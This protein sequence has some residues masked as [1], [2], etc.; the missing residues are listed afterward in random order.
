MQ[1][2][3]T[4]K[5]KNKT[6]T[7]NILITGAGGYIGSYLLNFLGKNTPNHIIPLSKKWPEHFY[8]WKDKFNVIEADVT[9]LD[10]LQEKIPQKIDIII[11]LAA[12]NNIKTAKMPEKALIVNGIGT[13]NMLDVA[14]ERNCRLFIYFSVLQ[15]YGKELA[16][17]ITVDSSLNCSDDYALTHF[18]AEEY[19]RMLSLKYGLN[20]SVVRLAN[21]CGCPLHRKVDRWTLVPGCFCL[22]AYKDKVIRLKSSGRQTRDF[23]SFEYIGKCIKHLIEKRPNGFNIYNLTSENV[24]PIIEIAEMV[25]SSAQSILNKNVRIICESRYPL[26]S[27]QFSVKNNLLKPPE[28]KESRHIL[29]Q[30]I[31]KTLKMLS[32]KNL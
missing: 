9:K 18:V 26:R 29:S 15:V 16:G 23:V 25:K 1:M 4:K 27:N 32:I 3:S 24:F 5:L 11:H 14:R 22:S 13:R 28:K 19:C 10:E 6:E 30:E 12:L 2:Q 20:A 31:E 21:V 17:T 7:M 8:D